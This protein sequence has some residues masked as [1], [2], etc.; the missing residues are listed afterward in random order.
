MNSLTTAPAGHDAR[1]MACR[2]VARLLIAAAAL[3][4]AVTP[5]EARAELPP[6]I[7]R[8]VLFGNPDKADPELSPDGTRLAYLAPDDGVLNVW[9]RTIGRKDDRPVT[10]DRKRGIRT[11]AWL[12][13]GTHIIF[14]QDKNGDENWHV[15]AVNLED[16]GQRDLTPFDK[17]Q[18]KVLQMSPEFPTELLVA[19]NRRDPA[20]HDVYRL[21]VGTGTRE[22][23]YENDQNYIGFLA[24]HDFMVRLAMASRD[25][26][27]VDVFVREDAETPWRPLHSWGPVDLIHAGAIAF[28]PDNEGLYILSSV[29]SNTS[30]LRTIDIASGKVRRLAGDPRADV[31]DY[32]LH[33]TRHTIQAVGFLKDRM[34]WEV[35]D[36]DIRD[37]FDVIRRLRRGSCK[38]VNRDR[39]DRTWLVLVDSDIG[40][41]Q[42]YVYNRETKS[43]ALLFSTR[44]ALEDIALA[45]MEPIRYTARDGLRINAYLTTPR[46]LPMKQLP[47]VVLVHPGPWARDDWGFDAEAQWLANRGYVVLQVNYRGSIGFGKDFVNAANRDWGGA[48]QTDLLDGVQWAVKR[49]IADPKRVAIMGSGYGGYA[50]M[51]GLAQTPDV[52]ACGVSANGPPDL[53]S[54]I[55][56]LIETRQGIA[57]IISDRLGHPERDVKQLR[58]R[59]PSH[60]VD[61]INKPLLVA[62]GTNSPRIPT[63]TV[64]DLIAALKESGKPVTFVEYPNEG[65]S[66]AVPENRL[67][68]YARV[69]RFLAK[70]IGGRVQPAPTPEPTPAGEPADDA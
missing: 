40:P 25:D 54:F 43:G 6:I 53:V 65:D 2:T 4:P 38:I 66:L 20:Y 44:E 52:Y 9:V 1:I 28:T 34:R 26:G 69:E 17:V 19:L 27:G 42:Y 31:A 29:G 56:R 67:D 24:D 37:D 47:M 18:A 35:L 61:R 12:Y 55:Q 45:K 11:F 16:G 32:V 39:A 46:G 68:F 59:S 60:M 22:L 57:T 51:V 7:P 5:S 33:P 50:A 36:D 49:G 70:H 23:V 48:M 21:D 41:P 14:I 3:Q 62:H 15:Y 8:D 13:D 10:H 64:R 63:E 58:R 30:E